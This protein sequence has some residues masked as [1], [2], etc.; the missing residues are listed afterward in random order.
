[1]GRGSKENGRVGRMAMD[2]LCARVKA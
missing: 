2:W 1:M